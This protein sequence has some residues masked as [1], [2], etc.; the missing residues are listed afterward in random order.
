VTYLWHQ[1]GIAPTASDDAVAQQLRICGRLTGRG[2]AQ[3]A[4]P[5][6]PQAFPASISAWPGVL[7]A[8]G[9]RLG[10]SASMRSIRSMPISFGVA[11]PQTEALQIV[12]EA[13]FE[14][15]RIYARGS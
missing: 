10:G 6:A 12:D 14:H 3:A 15:S 9:G 13:Q 2:S 7:L 5:R 8:L 1:H 4:S 11:A